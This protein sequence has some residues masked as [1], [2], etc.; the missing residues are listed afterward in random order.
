MNYEQRVRRKECSVERTVDVIGG[1]WTTL[2]VRELLRGTRRYGE[3]RAALAGVSPKTLT[4]KLRELE[5]GGVLTRTV[6]PAVPPRVEYALTPKG[7]ALEGV[8]QAMHV[9]GERWT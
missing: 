3:L 4:D 8:I 5:E 6:Y 9:W 2:I 7:R 1:K